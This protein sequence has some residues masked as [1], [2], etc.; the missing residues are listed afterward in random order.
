MVKKKQENK[1]GGFLEVIRPSWVKVIV[2]IIFLVLLYLFFA[3]SVRVNYLCAVPGEQC[4]K[5]TSD[6]IQKL[7]L[8][9][10]L[11]F[12]IPLAV[13]LWIIVGLIE[14]KFRRK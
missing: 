5:E 12:G 14:I 7:A 3:S 8:Q 10:T 4:I 6:I 1:K 2:V 11:I 9:D 13:V